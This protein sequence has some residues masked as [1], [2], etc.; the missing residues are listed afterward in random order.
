MKYNLDGSVECYKA[1]LV[2]K[3]YAQIYSVDYA[4][5]LSHV[6]KIAYV[7]ILISLAPNLG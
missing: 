1:L 2:A 3:G 4:K 7:R 6:A 5:T